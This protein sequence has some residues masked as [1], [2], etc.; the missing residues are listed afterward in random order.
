MN[1]EEFEIRASGGVDHRIVQCDCCFGSGKQEREE[2]FYVPM[3][4]IPVIESIL[5]N[6]QKALK[7]ADR[8][9][10][11][12]FV[13][14]GLI[15]A[16]AFFFGPHRFLYNTSWVFVLI[17]ISMLLLAYFGSVTYPYI[18]SRLELKKTPAFS[19][20]VS[21]GSTAL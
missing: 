14:L 12:F 16:A 6:Y 18:V 11:Y 15:P 20:S 1:R 13:A 7:R 9:F 4:D 10:S 2:I 8:W 19:V 3:D 17:L 5:K 21:A